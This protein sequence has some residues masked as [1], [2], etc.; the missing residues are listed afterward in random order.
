MGRKTYYPLTVHRWNTTESMEKKEDEADEYVEKYIRHHFRTPPLFYDAP[1]DSIGPLLFYVWP[2]PGTKA[3]IPKFELG[4]ILQPTRI[5]RATIYVKLSVVRRLTAE[6]YASHLCAVTLELFSALARR[7]KLDTRRLDRAVK[8]CPPPVGPSPFFGGRP[9][10]G[11]APKRAG[12]H[13]VQVDLVV[14]LRGKSFRASDEE[15]RWIWPL[16]EAIEDRLSE[17]KIGELASREAGR[18]ECEFSMTGF[19][20]ASLMA[21]AKR[22]LKSLGTRLPHGS[23]FLVHRFDDSVPDRKVPLPADLLAAR[24]STR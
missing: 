10:T 12:E 8:N 9:R 14:P 22:V 15:L 3:D 1:F 23:H 19:R 18:G 24:R 16:H 11:K 5:Q 2:G 17:E 21:V 13:T 7:H 6:Q 4:K 20:S